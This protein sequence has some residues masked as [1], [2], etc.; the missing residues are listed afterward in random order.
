MREISGLVLRISGLTLQAPA[1]AAAA[2]PCD[3]EK[4]PEHPLG[5]F[6]CPAGGIPA[7][8]LNVFETHR[9]SFGPSQSKATE[10]K[11]TVDILAERL[12]GGPSGAIRIAAAWDV[13]VAD[14]EVVEGS[15]LISLL[16][17]VAPRTCT[18]CCLKK[19]ST[20]L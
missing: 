8:Q 6:V 16:G 11:V 13:G 4:N 7:G 18:C 15:V 5:A 20:P 10:H 1:S 9:L 3:E 14:R 17:W 2:E 12:R 19:V